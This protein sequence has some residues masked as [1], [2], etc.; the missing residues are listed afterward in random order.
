MGA[1]ALDGLIMPPLEIQRPRPGTNKWLDLLA[2]YPHQTQDWDPDLLDLPPRPRLMEIQRVENDSSLGNLDALPNELLAKMMSYLDFQSLS[3]LMQVSRKGNA[4]VDSMPEYKGI[5][6]HAS[7]TLLALSLTKLITHHSATLLWFVLRNEK[8]SYCGESGFRL[9]LPTCTRCCWFCFRYN[10]YLRMVPI[11]MAADVFGLSLDHISSLI[12]LHSTRKYS[13]HQYAYPSLLQP[14]S[15]RYG[16]MSRPV[17]AF[18]PIMGD[19]G[20]VSSLKMVSAGEAKKLSL[21]IQRAENWDEYLDDRIQM[22]ESRNIGNRD[23]FELLT[24]AP[25]EPYNLDRA[26][27]RSQYPHGYLNDEFGCDCSITFPLLTWN[28]DIDIGR[29]C[30]GCYWISQK[31][32]WDKRMIEEAPDLE[33]RACVAQMF[34]EKLRRSWTKEDFPNH[35]KKCEGAKWLASANDEEWRFFFRTKKLLTDV[36]GKT[37]RERFEAV[38]RLVA[39][40]NGLSVD[41]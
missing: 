38:V 27:L 6:E 1:D 29:L 9:Y 22:L 26:A 40:S 18:P 3:R 34:T 36:N 32:L 16:P 10:P 17:F 4:I 8:C 41:D 15:E 28:G 13:E 7:P 11:D 30:Y 23:Y 25:P 24:N 39:E 21:R 12:T 33:G 37:L 31:Q 20:P 5:M 19:S 14:S 35:I 2:L